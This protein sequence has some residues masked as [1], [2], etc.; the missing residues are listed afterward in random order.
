[1][2]GPTLKAQ[3]RMQ[4]RYRKAH[5]AALKSIETHR[6]LIDF[7]A[8][9]MGEAYREMMRRGIERAFMNV[10]WQWAG[11]NLPN[12]YDDA[13]VIAF[14][15]YERRIATEHP[16]AKKARARRAAQS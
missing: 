5:F 2:R 4:E 9:N 1:M 7:I 13:N 12:E 10:H 11:E 8:G 3:L 15:H 14:P 6:S 16:A